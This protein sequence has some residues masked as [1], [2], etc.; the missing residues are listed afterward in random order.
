MNVPI[1]F[2]SIYLCS[3]NSEQMSPQGTLQKKIISIQSY[4]PMDPSYQTVLY[5]QLIIQCRLNSY[6]KKKRFLQ[7]KLLFE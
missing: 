5:A 2:N 6:E 1:Q 4:I 3:A 7:F